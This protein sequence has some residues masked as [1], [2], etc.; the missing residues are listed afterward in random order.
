LTLVKVNG[1][2]LTAGHSQWL[3]MLMCSDMGC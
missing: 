1:Q 2:W 3:G